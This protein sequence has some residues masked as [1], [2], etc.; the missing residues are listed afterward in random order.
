M[1]LNLEQIQRSAQWKEVEET[2]MEDVCLPIA[3]RMSW[4]RRKGFEEQAG[5]S[6]EMKLTKPKVDDHSGVPSVG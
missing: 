4:K 3:Q 2:E 6:V 1:R 5:G